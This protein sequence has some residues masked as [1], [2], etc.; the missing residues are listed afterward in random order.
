MHVHQPSGCTLKLL[1][2]VGLGHLLYKERLQHLVR[3]PSAPSPPFLCP[4]TPPPQPSPT[5]LPG[6][7]AQIFPSFASNVDVKVHCVSPTGLCTSPCFR[8]L[9]G[10]DRG[11]VT[12]GVVVM[13][14][15]GVRHVNA[16][17]VAMGTPNVDIKLVL[18]PGILQSASALED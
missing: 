9:G 11:C 5:S 7:S 16:R 1:T 10:D 6:H 12:S 3:P 15:S 17:G 4:I 14:T 18:L 2:R 8:R 13:S